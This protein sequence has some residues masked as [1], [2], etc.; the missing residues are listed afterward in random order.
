[1]R[2]REFDEKERLIK[3]NKKLTKYKTA[4]GA[5]AAA[6]DAAGNFARGHKR[7]KGINAATK[8]Q[9]DNDAKLSQLKEFAPGSGGGESGRWY[10][11]DQITDLV[12]DGWW[13]DLDVSG[14]NIGVIDSEVPKEYMIQQAQAWLDDQGYS[15]QVLNC[16]LN[17]DDM[18]W[19]I[20]GSFHN[21]GF[22]KKGVAEEW[23][24]KYKNSIN[25]SHPK[26]FSQRAHCAGKKK[27][28]ES[29]EMEMVCED[30][31]MCQTHGSLNEIAK[32]EKDS[33][34]YT[35]CWPGK[36]AEGTKTGKNGGQVRDCV[37]NES[38]NESV[39]EQVGTFSSNNM[40]M[41]V[42]AARFRAQ[43]DL[44]RKKYG[45]NFQDKPGLGMHYNQD[46]QTIA[47]P[48][49]PGNYY[50]TVTLKPKDYP[51]SPNLTARP[52]MAPD[53][54]FDYFHKG[55]QLTTDHPLYNR[56][57]QLHQDSLRPAAEPDNPA[58]E[59][60]EE[61]NNRCRQCGM[62]NCKC[63]GDSCKCKPI[64]GWIPN[65]GFRK[66]AEQSVAEDSLAAMR[67]LAGVSTPPPAAVPNGPRQYRHMPT[68]VQP[69]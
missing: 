12:G 34:G 29:I 50:S 60:V 58:N 1:M 32:G 17:D 65:K 11:D 14:A 39:N 25:C 8:K 4:A 13:N 26:G 23:S 66:A 69:R 9:F 57:K 35:R 21:P 40:Q 68:A 27:H 19:F 52:S 31:G 67:R 49:K 38:V 59:S 18:D 22:A 43:Q 36:H 62:I 16:R 6:A 15:V 10:T 7:F 51:L 63:P 54:D 20:E 46:V 48:K 45:D 2:L 3:A 24:Q 53:Q 42:D 64:A 5:D 37:P 55:E 33:N 56:V 44:L 61:S 47:D 41:S 28:N 30:C